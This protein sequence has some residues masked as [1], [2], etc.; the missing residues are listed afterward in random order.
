MN[1]QVAAWNAGDLNRFK[2]F[3]EKRGAETGAWRGE[4]GP[5]PEQSQSAA[6]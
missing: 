4:I 5:E 2:S 1:E 3:I 6:R